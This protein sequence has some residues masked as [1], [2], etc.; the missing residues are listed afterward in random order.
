MSGCKR[1][2]VEERFVGGWVCECDSED[3]DRM[4]KAG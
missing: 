3:N 4:E 1:R 2:G